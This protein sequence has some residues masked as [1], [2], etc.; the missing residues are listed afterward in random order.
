MNLAALD[1]AIAHI[2]AHPEQWDQGTW[3]TRYADGTIKR[4]VGGW[5]AA[6]AVGEDAIEWDEPC[7]TDVDGR[8]TQHL[9]RFSGDRYSD[10]VVSEALGLPYEVLHDSRLFQSSNTLAA[11]KAIR[12]DLAARYGEQEEVAQ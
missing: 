10:L 5:V 1:A 9:F 7:C 6:Q 4:C 8:P 11:I 2:E 12:D 3:G